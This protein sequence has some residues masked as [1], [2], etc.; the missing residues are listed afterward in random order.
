M[1]QPCIIATCSNSGDDDGML[2]DDATYWNL[3]W[4]PLCDCLSVTMCSALQLVDT[5][6]IRIGVLP[7]C[8]TCCSRMRSTSSV[9]I[10]GEWRHRPPFHSAVN[11]SH[12]LQRHRPAAPVEAVCRPRLV[13]LAVLAEGPL[14]HSAQSQLAEAPVRSACAKLCYSLLVYMYI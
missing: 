12:S 11:A 6:Y 4:L 14:A 7:S 5:N 10:L 2:K 3:G 9:V 1:K 8:S 13:G